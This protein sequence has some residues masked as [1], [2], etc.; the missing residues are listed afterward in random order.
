MRDPGNEVAVVLLL[1]VVFNFYS[2]IYTKS[3]LN[4]RTLLE[5]SCQSNSAN[6]AIFTLLTSISK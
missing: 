1:R 3:I 5:I 6:T 2:D 4:S